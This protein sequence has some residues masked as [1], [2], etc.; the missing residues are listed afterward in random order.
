[1]ID[2][3]YAMS[4]EIN[5]LFFL[6]SLLYFIFMSFTFMYLYLENKNQT[7]FKLSYI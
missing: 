1:M 2:H 7:S 6:S 5:F 3:C 4:G